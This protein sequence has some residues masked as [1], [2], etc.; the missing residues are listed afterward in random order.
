MRRGI[1]GD[2]DGGLGSAHMELG[3]SPGDA[4][5]WQAFA[6]GSGRP[7]ALSAG[8]TGH[9]RQGP[10]LPISAPPAQDQRQQLSLLQRPLTMSLLPSRLLVTATT[11]VAYR[12]P[13]P[14]ASRHH[15]QR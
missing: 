8:L 3:A 1:Q 13:A 12:R 15:G 14:R 5:P 7:R 11:A 2:A 10:S 4:G 6:Q 9:L